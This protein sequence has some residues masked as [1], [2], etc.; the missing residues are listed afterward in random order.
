MVVTHDQQVAARTRRQVQMLDGRI[1]SDTAAGTG[2]TAERLSG[3][4]ARPGG[5]DR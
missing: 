1:V 2:E 4:P 5:E 3:W